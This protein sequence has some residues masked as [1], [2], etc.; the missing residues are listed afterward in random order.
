MFDDFE[1]GNDGGWFQPTDT[2]GTYAVITDGTNHVYQEQTTTSDEAWSVG[3]NINWTDQKLSVK[4]KW[5]SSGDPGNSL[6]VLAL[7][8]TDMDSYYFI[9][10][11]EDGRVKIRVRDAGS[12]TDLGTYD[13][14]V[15]FVLGTWYTLVFEAKGSQIT[16]SVDGTVWLTVADTSLT[17]GGIAIGARDAVVSFDDVTVTVP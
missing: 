17:S 10:L 7:R 15:A 3:G 4:V 5:V 2:T 13:S 6:V 11:R 1:D 8:L 16:V 12:T 9:E 14:N